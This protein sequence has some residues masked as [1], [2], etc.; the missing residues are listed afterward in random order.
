MDA[1]VA[2]GRAK[3]VG[4]RPP[5]AA[6]FSQAGTTPTTRRSLRWAVA[7]Q[8]DLQATLG[9]GDRRWWHSGQFNSHN[10]Q[11]GGYWAAFLRQVGL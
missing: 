5:S 8:V 1:D 11:V 6:D 4:R 7:A 9:F 3:G 10:M 2:R